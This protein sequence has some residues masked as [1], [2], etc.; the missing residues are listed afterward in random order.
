MNMYLLKGKHVNIYEQRMKKKTFFKII[1]YRISMMNT[2]HQQNG[3]LTEFSS[4]H[5]TKFV[6]GYYHFPTQSVHN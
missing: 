5:S 6:L 1:Y 3:T 4:A 2:K